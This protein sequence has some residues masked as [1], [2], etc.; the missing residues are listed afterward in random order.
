MKL[1]AAGFSSIG[2]TK[3]YLKRLQNTFRRADRAEAPN[4]AAETGDNTRHFKSV[5]VKLQIGEKKLPGKQKFSGE[6]EQLEL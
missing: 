2:Q 6:F 5:Q 4:P 3:R 1:P